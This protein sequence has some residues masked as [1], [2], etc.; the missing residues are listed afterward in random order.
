[1]GLIGFLPTKGISLRRCVIS[2]LANG[3]IGGMDFSSAE[4]KKIATSYLSRMAAV[5][6]DSRSRDY[7]C[8]ICKVKNIELL[9]DADPSTE[10]QAS[11]DTPL[12]L[13]FGYQKDH[14]TPSNSASG[15]SRFSPEIADA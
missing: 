6:S 10:T 2:F 3:A 1:M 12:K 14:N 15:K 7:I 8:P 9:P 5:G 13:S 11:K 4:R